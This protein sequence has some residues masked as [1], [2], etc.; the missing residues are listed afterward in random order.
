VAKVVL[1]IGASH[2][3]STFAPPSTWEFY[4]ERDRHRRI[5]QTLLDRADG[6]LEALASP[7]RWEGYFAAGQ[8]AQAVLNNIVDRAEPDVIVVFGDDQ[9]EQFHDD[10]MPMFA[11]YR[12]ESMSRGNRRR[13]RDIWAAEAAGASD[14]PADDSPLRIFDGAPDLAEHLIAHLVEAGIDLTCS[15]A[16]REDVGLGHAFT[17]VAENIPHIGE[18]AILP[19]MVNTYYPPNQPTA[20]RCVELGRHVREAIEL[21]DS[22]K[23]VAIMASGG[24]S[25]Q[26]ID[27]R[28]DRS[29]LDAFAHGDIAWLSSLPKE[30]FEGGTSEILNWITVTSAMEGDRATVVDYIPAYRTPAGTGLAMGFVYWGLSGSVSRKTKRNRETLHL[31]RCSHSDYSSSHVSIVGPERRT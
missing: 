7:D 8:H 11:I 28:L 3:S 31:S 1:G 22:G 2:G 30:T 6:S 12:G 29:L 26:T 27:E 18:R 9:H 5:Y 16:L 20:A 21:W 24:L 17:H 10:N 4:A 14:E 15:N 25:H 23:R 13:Q 19:F